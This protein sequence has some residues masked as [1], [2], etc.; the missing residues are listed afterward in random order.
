MKKVLI[1][2]LAAGIFVGCNTIKDEKACSKAELSACKKAKAAK[3]AKAKA[4]CP[5]KAKAAKCA[6]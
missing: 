1:A 6:K 3:C 2:I 5:K 4:A